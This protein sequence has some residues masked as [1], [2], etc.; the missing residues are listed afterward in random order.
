MQAGNTTIRVVE[1][2]LTQQDV[3]A[4]VNAANEWL[5][6]GGGVAAAIANA[7]G[8]ILQEESDSYVEACGPISI[9]TSV[10]T[11]AGDMPA[12]WVVHTVGPRYREGNDNE[13]ELRAA[14]S[15]ALDSGALQGARSMAF[16]A[17][18]AGIFGYPRPEATSVISSEV[19]A[20][21]N[22]H[23][24][25]LNEVLLVGFDSDTAKDF[26]AGLEEAAS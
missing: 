16:P 20:W 14:V 2:D 11:S 13:A 18:S 19:V 21:C 15:S 23:P 26:T 6:H 10:V 17:I 24:D 1:G 12:R 7:A 4:V 8:P 9:G 22:H 3:D 25:S 5:H